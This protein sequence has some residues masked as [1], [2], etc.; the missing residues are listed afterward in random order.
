MV[1]EV[2]EDCVRGRDA[3]RAEEA[4]W[5]R[6]LSVPARFAGS[7]HADAHARR[8]LSVPSGVARRPCR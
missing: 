6:L 7:R 3:G 5:A 1:R 8:T 2:G 4:E